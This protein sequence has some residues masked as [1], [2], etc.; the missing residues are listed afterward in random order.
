VSDEAA[1][2]DLDFGRIVERVRT[3]DLPPR[4][5]VDAVVAIARG[6]T[7]PGALIAYRLE[8]PLRLMRVSFRDD[9]NRPSRD[10][11]QAVGEL[12]DVRGQRIVL[13]D[14]VTVSG[15]TLRRA[16][17][18]L[19]AAR[20]TTVAFKGA[21]DAADVVLF[22]DVPRCVRW[23]WFEDVPPSPRPAAPPRAIVLAGV[24]GSGKTTVGRGLAER[25]G[26][27]YVEAD[28]HH[29]PENVAKMRRGE[30]LNDADRAPWLA[31]LRRELDR[32]LAEGRGVVLSSS[33]LKADYRR[34]LTGG[35]DEIAV[36]LLHGPQR[37]LADRLEQRRDH[38]FDASMLRSQLDTLEL[39]GPGEAA[40]VIGVEPEPDRIVD[41]IVRELRLSAAAD[42]PQHDPSSP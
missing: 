2:V 42:R 16:A 40:L 33:A 15:A 20:T 14:D 1:K 18:L 7:V 38:F 31:S 21:P 24:S 39:P 19:D 9:A 5:E 26:W 10:E 41:R 36:V 32:H 25:L 13:V 22:P 35:R 34:A 12:P 28:D 37:V 6:G 23:P 8:R 4:E 11:P 27:D 17:A 30:P 3:A 29:P